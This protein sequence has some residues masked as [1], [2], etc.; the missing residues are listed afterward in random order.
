MPRVVAAAPLYVSFDLPFNYGDL[1]FGSGLT[2]A[3][4]V[5]Q[6]LLAEDGGLL[7]DPEDQSFPI[8][9]GTL[10][11]VTGLLLEVI[12]QVEDARYFYSEGGRISI[13]F[14]LLLPSGLIQSGTFQAP[15]MGPYIIYGDFWETAGA[16]GIGQ[17]DAATAQLLGINPSTLPGSQGFYLD[18]YDAYPDPYRVAKS[19]GYIDIQV[20]P[21]PTVLSLALI[22][23]GAVALRYR[24]R[25]GRSIR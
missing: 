20:V 22:G 9:G 21:E 15:L 18:L 11:F 12:P 19:F 5:D 2:L 8:V 17:F 24:R 4:I 6:P 23:V 3:R 14:D 25:T 13:A 10:N 7:V 16:L 1:E